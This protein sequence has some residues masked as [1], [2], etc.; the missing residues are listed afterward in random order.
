VSRM[1]AGLVSTAAGPVA[2]DADRLIRMSQRFREDLKDQ[3]G[4]AMTHLWPDLAHFAVGHI[5]FA[6][7]IYLKGAL[8]YLLWYHLYEAAS[9]GWWERTNRRLQ[10]ERGRVMTGYR[11]GGRI[12]WTPW[13]IGA[14]TQTMPA[15]R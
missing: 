3:P 5:P 4:K 12:P 1:G 10:K 6:N 13:G 7:L 2:S 15:N 11:P 9:P 8:D 14:A